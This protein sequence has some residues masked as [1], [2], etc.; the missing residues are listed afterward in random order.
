[1]LAAIGDSYTQAYSTS[2][3]DLRDHPQYSW[4]VGTA[5]NDGITSLLE[6][7]RALGG[8]PVV[9]D[10]ATS[11][12]KMNDA[13]RQAE[14]VVAAAQ[15]L[16]PGK[17]VYVVFELGTND[18]CDDP[19]TS[20]TEFTDQA[21]TAVGI[22]RVG[23]PPGSRLLMDPL[24][25]FSHFRAI[26]QADPTARKAFTLYQ[27]SRR[28]APFLGSGSP[29]SIPD[30]EKILSDYDGALETVCGEVNAV[31]G[32]LANLHC[33][34]NEELLSDRDFKIGDLSTVDYFHP[35]KSG[36]AKMAAAAWRADAWANATASSHGGVFAALA[37]APAPAVAA[38][39][40]RRRWRPAAGLRAAPARPEPTARRARRA[41]NRG[42]GAVAVPVTTRRPPIRCR[43]PSA[44]SSAPTAS[45]SR[46]ARS[47]SGMARS[48]S[49]AAARWRPRSP[50]SMGVPWLRTSPREPRGAGGGGR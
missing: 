19:K 12:K 49:P 14:A 25:D 7:F 21:R 4:V 42:Q 15:N 10:A 37:L 29:V 18:L 20:L 5:K 31:T 24:P 11:G 33:T 13:Q 39:K 27:N 45:A 30:A 26:T 28:C 43:R 17:T 35:S 6:H 41:A 40:R 22:L 48:A 50:A 23:L 38:L 8:S 36:Q 46:R 16:D 1:M 47:R 3:S 34:Y 2:P 44:S 32:A 9:V